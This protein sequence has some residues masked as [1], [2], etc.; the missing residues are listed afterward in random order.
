MTHQSSAWLLQLY[1]K[2]P[3]CVKG[4]ETALTEQEVALEVAAGLLSLED[5]DA[6]DILKVGISPNYTP[7]KIQ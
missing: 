1:L 6:E 2:L 3:K 7:W 4:A 5:F